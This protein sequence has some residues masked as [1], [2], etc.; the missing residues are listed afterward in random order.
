MLASLLLWPN[1]GLSEGNTMMHPDDL[2][3][4]IFAVAIIVLMV[5]GII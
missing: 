3:I 2:G 1:S 5:I 4:A